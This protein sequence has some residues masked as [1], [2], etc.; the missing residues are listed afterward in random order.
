MSANVT[1]TS[2]K[3]ILLVAANPAVSSTTGWPIGFWWAELTHPYWAFTEAGYEVEIR[4]PDGGALQADAY[5]DPE[6]ASGYSAH[7][8]LSLG[9]KKSPKLAALLADTRSVA[10]VSVGDYAAIFVI[11]GQ[12][13]MV[14]F[15]GNQRLQRLVAAFHEAGKVTALVCHGT[16]LLLETRLSSG[17]L[18]VKGKRWTGFAS[19]EE[20]FAD[21]FVGK[22]IQPFWIEDEARKLPDT[23][24]EAAG[25]FQAHAIRDGH[26]VT[27]QQQNSGAAAA[28]L[29]LELL[30][31]PEQ[32][33]GQRVI[34]NTVTIARHE[35][36]FFK[37]N[38]WLVMNDEHAVLLD[39]ACNDA[40]D[41]ER[42]VSFV[43]ASGRR[44]QAVILSH[45]HPD[46]WLGVRSLK[47]A[48]PAAPIYVASPAVR[49]DI[50]EMA[51]IIESAG[52]LA[53]P[54]LS[55][56]RFDYREAIQVLGSSTL[57]L[58]GSPSVT[59]EL[60]VTREP[61]EHTRLTTVYVPELDTLLVS[62]LAYNRV[63]SWAGVGVSRP[64]LVSWLGQLDELVTRHANGSVRVL[65]GHG[66][67]AD[68]NL[69]LAQRDYLRRMLDAIDATPDAGAFRARML[70]DFPGFGGE[71]FQLAMTGKNLGALGALARGDAPRSTSIPQEGDSHANSVHWAR[72]G[73]RR[74]GGWAAAAGSRGHAGG[75]RRG[76][77]VGGPRA[78]PQRRASGGLAARRGGKGA[79][80]V[81]RHPV[82]GHRRR[83]RPR[84]RS[85]RG[86]GAGRL[87]QPGRAGALAR[88]GEQA[89][90]QRA[91]AAAG[92]R[93]TRGQGV[94]DLRVREPREQRI[95]CVRGPPR[96]ADRGGRR[97]GQGRRERAVPRAR[98]GARGHRPAR[99]C[100]APRAHDAALGEDGEGAGPPERAGVGGAAALREDRP[101]GRADPGKGP[102]GVKGERVVASGAL[103]LHPRRGRCPL[104]PQRGAA[105]A[106]RPRE[107]GL[108]APSLLAISHPGFVHFSRRSV[109]PHAPWRPR[110][111]VR[112]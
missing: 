20:Q 88:A 26:L 112:V 41:G 29:V 72:T 80:G 81:P 54:E 11:G 99:S 101:S 48:F 30:G 85:A 7:D 87:H 45:G 64:A 47:E 96:D 67:P 68:A 98:V 102:D 3:K 61:S 55:A 104:H 2:T 91:T 10:D 105:P 70:A 56:K 86:Q 18:L 79:R 38:A 111:H 63:H 35:H 60:T 24:F 36:P 16:C 43:K 25:R 52:L 77:G 5:S 69:L 71:N 62:D 34:G 75:E 78:R 13:P 108:A 4:S 49:D 83:D 8:L 90:G 9:F 12:S 32:P 39:T 51:G 93:R 44:L 109:G 21:D 76:G 84:R 46:I 58:E 73:R 27:G 97:R 94:H 66:E 106:P 28:Q 107:K 82:L 37:A 1:T 33:R 92:A 74:A 110:V 22:R 95:P 100:A 17:E 57:K 42:L 40:S 15:R 31:S 6:D 103:P 59:F 19:S 65:P 50:V 23:S 53:S 14:T 89:V